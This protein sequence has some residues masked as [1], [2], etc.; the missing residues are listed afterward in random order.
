MKNQTLY[1]TLQEAP[2]INDRLRMAV[3]IT[4][5]SLDAQFLR[6]KPLAVDIS[7]HEKS[8]IQGYQRNQGA[9]NVILDLAVEGDR[10]VYDTLRMLR[11]S[12][13]EK[14]TRQR[15]DL[16]QLITGTESAYRQHEVKAAAGSFATTTLLTTA[17]CAASGVVLAYGCKD[18]A[19]AEYASML[20]VFAGS[21]GLGT[22]SIVGGLSAKESI[23][24]HHADIQLADQ[25]AHYIDNKIAELYH[26][27]IQR[28]EGS[29]LPPPYKSQQGGA[30]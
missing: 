17:L 4:E 5:G 7:E 20:P 12:P 28:T 2:G 16:A 1:Q 18:A 26:A 29:R 8:L 14:F 13:K 22:G 6:K 24:D 9:G 30:A 21:M 27:P 3:A 10:T 25:Q 15:E 23:N 19:F 11:A